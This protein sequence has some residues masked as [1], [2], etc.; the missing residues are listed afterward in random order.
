MSWF[1]VD[2]TFFSIREK[3]EEFWQRGSRSSD[4]SAGV[5]PRWQAHFGALGAVSVGNAVL[6][7]IGGGGAWVS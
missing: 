7:G 2:G 4:N 6:M 3:R 1:A 5:N